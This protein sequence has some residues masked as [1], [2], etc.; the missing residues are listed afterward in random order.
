MELLVKTL[1]DHA[2]TI[3]NYLNYRSLF[4]INL[5]EIDSRSKSCRT[6]HTLLIEHVA[7]DD[8]IFLTLQHALFLSF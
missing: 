4:S 3:I 6:L 2:Q 7:A 5:Y 8:I 1:L